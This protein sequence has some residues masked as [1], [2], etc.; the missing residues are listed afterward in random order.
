V[1]LAQDRRLTELTFATY[2]ESWLATRK[3][4]GRSLAPR[5]Q[6]GYRKLLDR[7]L[8]PTF[9]AMALK[10][11]TPDA[12]LAW[13]E[14]AT[15]PERHLLAMRPTLRAQAYVLLKSI[16]ASAADPAQTGGARIPFNPCA[17]RGGGRA[18]R[19]SKTEILSPADLATIAD[20]MPAQ[21]RLLVLLAGWCA[22]R[23]GEVRELRRGDVHINEG[24][25]RVSRA[26][27]KGNLVGPPKTAAGVRDVGIPP[28][29]LAE[30]RRHLLEHAQSG[31]QGSLFCGARGGH[32]PEAVLW[33]EFDRAKNAAGRPGLRFHDLRHSGLTWLAQG[34]ATVGEL[35]AWAGHTTP[36]VAMRYQHLA[37]DRKRVLAKRLDAMRS[38]TSE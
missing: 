3:V 17:V 31:A 7:L 21:H 12:L 8:L 2:A 4:K 33:Q 19:V 23:S 14:G 11:I 29:L 13:Y 10:A 16:L 28:S 20:A 6:D 15:T 38:G 27:G 24:F 18:E 30:L 22:L 25:L 1:R 26:V 35:Q 9:G 36:A 37:Q 5:T 34:G 32:L